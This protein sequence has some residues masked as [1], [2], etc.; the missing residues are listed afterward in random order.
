MSDT[1]GDGDQNDSELEVSRLDAGV[2]GVAAHAQP[3]SRESAPGERPR[4]WWARASVT[5]LVVALA[6]AVILASFPG[7]SNRLG[8]PL[9]PFSP[10]LTI[11]PGSD[12]IL[13][14]HTVPWG[15][16]HLERTDLHPIFLGY[17][18]TYP[19]Y[20]LPPGQHTLFYVAAPFSP[21]Q[22]KVTVPRRSD[23]DCKLATSGDAPA[24]DT[25]ASMRLIDASASFKLLDPG[26]RSELQKL[27]E[28][29]IAHPPLTVEPGTHYLDQDAHV[30]VARERMTVT[31]AMGAATPPSDVVLFD[32]D[33]QPCGDIC[34]LDNDQD[35]LAWKLTIWAAPRWTYVSATGSAFTAH[36]EPSDAHTSASVLWQDGKWIL[37]TQNGLGSPCDFRIFIE[38]VSERTIGAG[39]DTFTQYGGNSPVIANP[40]NGCVFEF[41]AQED[42]GDH[43]QPE[44]LYR[45]G[46]LLAANADAQRIFPDL[47]VANAAERAIAQ[48]IRAGAVQ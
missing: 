19:S 38:L 48:S 16:L 29:G 14:A 26:A 1:D 15:E 46:V 37:N 6:L 7:I 18:E 2:P 3:A 24:T 32:D 10:T 8:G 47:P 30:A 31:M 21:M 9:H 11:P 34:N 27:L 35:Y 22:C 20:R 28:T 5:G 25:S 44:I 40:A 12:I 33:D 39:L 13:L 45:L 17:K 43:P 42:P 41:H 23:D 4:R 36:G